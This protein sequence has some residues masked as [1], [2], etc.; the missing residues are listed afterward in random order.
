M[1]SFFVAFLLALA[2]TGSLT[3]QVQYEP[4]WESLDTRKMP[5]WFSQDKFGIFIHWGVYS[6]PSFAPV[7]ADGYSEW[8]WKSLLDTS[9]TNHK[10]TLNF[11]KKNYGADFSYFDF[12]P[13][14]KA[15][16]FNPDQWADVFKKSGAKYVV[17]TSKHHEGYTLWPDKYSSQAYGRKWN[18]AEI[19]PERDVLGELTK[20]VRNTGLKMGYYYSLYEWFNPLWL[21]NRQA[22]VDQYMIPQLKDLVTKYDPSILFFDG[23]WSMTADK[24]KSEEILAWLFNRNKDLVVND[25]LGKETRG[26]HPSTY[27]TSEYGSGMKPGVIWEENRGL[28][29]SFGYNRMERASDYKT[30]E[31]LIVILADIVSR[32][33]NLL[34]DI[35]PAADGRIPEIMEDRLLQMGKW[36]AVNGEAIYGTQA[37]T[38]QVQWSEGQRPKVKEGNYQTDY[39]VT[40]FVH[41]KEVGNAYIQ[42]FF[43]QKNNAV[44]CIVPSKQS[45]LLVKDINSAKSVSILGLNNKLKWKKRDNGLFI[46]LN[47]LETQRLPEGPFVIKIQL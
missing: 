17:L 4:K 34:L 32:G 29:F 23:E 1:K 14:L 25:R 36:L 40:K 15:E 37:W 39:D 11:H 9:R 45:S 16:L 30:T 20:S 41:Q 33:G 38:N 12:A 18:A 26:K 13:S 28:G 10:S 27:Y 2:T 19:G 44:Y 22:Y 21:N 6:V 24:W 43:T 8:Y 7:M 3:A 35:G 31:E 46:E 47:N 5:A 42:S